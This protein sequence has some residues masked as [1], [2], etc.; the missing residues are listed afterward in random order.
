MNPLAST[1]YSRRL[2][3]ALAMTTSILLIA[4]C[5]S[6]GTPTP[7]NNQG[8]TNASLTGTYVISMAGTDVNGGDEIVPFAIVGT[9]VA[10]G[11]GG[12]TGTIDI[13]DPANLGVTLGA[14]IS[15]PQSS[16]NISPDGRA[17]GTLVTTVANF[18]IDFVLT[19]PNHG[20]ITRFDSLGTGSG[21]MD[22]QS[23][24]TQSQLASLAFTLSGADQNGP[25]GSVGAFTLNSTTGAITAGTQDFNNDG[26]SGA[27]YTDLA[28]SGNV[29]LAGS[30]TT[31]TSTLTTSNTTIS[32]TGSLAFDVWVIDPTHLKFIETDSL[33]TGVLLSGDAFTQQTSFTP[34]Q[35]V[36]TLGGTDASGNPVVAGGYATTDAN[37]N[38]SAGIE[39]YNDFGTG[40]LGK[41]F[42][43]SSSACNTTN[44]RC[45]TTLNGFTNGIS[46]AFTF[47]SYPSSG[48]ALALEID[49]FGLLQGA[50]Y[51]QSATSLAAT[52]YALNLS[53]A[54]T[55]GEGDVAEV[56][57]IA[58]FN[59]TAAVSPA[60]NMTGILDEN[61]LLGGP[62]PRQTL[63]GT[64][65]PDSTPD[66]RGSIV[67]TTGNTFIGGISL[68]Y[69]VVNA[70]TVVFI[71]VDQD[72]FTV[73]SFQSQGSSGGVAQSHL[74]MAHSAVRPHAT[75][76]RSK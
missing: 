37:A 2:L 26:T 23:S 56:D 39:D 42:A 51:T 57:D 10:N 60:I 38:L 48:G 59:A 32:P 73:G 49:S 63:S 34:G 8:F 70:A 53:G 58:Q 71:E 43:S 24:A 75:L 30:G 33:A 20:L 12:L 1:K 6:S 7:P 3:M 74:S 61:S 68:Q 19:S 25:V 15:S 14:S 27:G 50:V 66:G 13:N 35:V 28:L 72:Q 45:Q 22:L 65:T 69:Y 41:P 17:T 44:G 46:E 21:T 9:I 29:V 4:G 40:A 76:R 55:D 36:F 47:A 31:G 67:A 52:G 18:N 62:T 11:N 64:Y 16:Y 5:G 54:N